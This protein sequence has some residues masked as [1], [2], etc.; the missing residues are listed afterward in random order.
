MPIRLHL[1]RA[2]HLSVIV[3]YV[4]TLSL[5]VEALL[6]QA[7]LDHIELD[8]S[9]QLILE[10]KVWRFLELAA[11]M[12]GMSHLGG[13]LAE[14]SHLSE[15]GEF[16]KQLLEAD[17]L[18]QALHFLIHKIG[19]H[20]NN[21]LFWL[22]ESEQ[23]VWICRP[24]YPYVKDKLWQAEQH[25]L[26][27]LCKVIENYAGDGWQ[28]KKIK[29]QDTVGLGL[30]QS[31]FFNDAEVELGQRYS[32]IAIEHD[33][34]EDRHLSKT[35][36]NSSKLDCIPDCFLQSF[37]LLLKQNYFGQ[38][39]LAENIA[40][41]LGT[42]VRTLKRKLHEQGTSLRK[43]FDEVRFQQACDLINQ[44]IYDYQE[45][46]EKL[47]YTHVNNFVR[48]FKRWSGITPREYMR[49]R[50]QQLLNKNGFW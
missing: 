17:N 50:D 25:V 37:K 5:P 42:S 20:N 29:L 4:R 49:L 38:G 9:N 31:R 11:E 14:D 2:S 28:P 48:A 6:E 23:C 12:K 39:W 35:F 44:D 30:D 41:S 34:L 33:L 45:L 15:Y 22:K 32:A 43:V 19:L 18:Y 13:L 27:L 46:A 3:Q 8:N 24:Q 7:D 26:S 1:I 47:S 21:S 16:T 10:T 40:S 36:S